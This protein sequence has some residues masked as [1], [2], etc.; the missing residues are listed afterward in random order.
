MGPVSTTGAT[1]AATTKSHVASTKEK[2]KSD[3]NHGAVSPVPVLLVN[4]DQRKRWTKVLSRKAKKT[5]RK[6]QNNS[7]VGTNKDKKTGRP[8][9]SGATNP[10]QKKKK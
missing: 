4:P 6:D 2:G 7:R 10:L 9:K 1:T 8:P 3:E 5:T